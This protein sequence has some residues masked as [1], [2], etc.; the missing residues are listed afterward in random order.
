M[1]INGREK[2]AR[3]ERDMSKAFSDWTGCVWD[4]TFQSGG[5][6][7]KG[8]IAPVNGASSICVELKRREAWSLDQ[9]LT[10]KGDIW[11]WWGKL[12]K[13]AR[14]GRQHPVLVVKKNKLDALVVMQGALYSKLFNTDPS[15]ALRAGG[16][17]VVRLVDFLATDGSKVVLTLDSIGAGD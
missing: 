7:Q 17:V 6:K 11:E 13:E 10:S 14:E 15:F 12:K 1:T 2:G 16:V 8:D 9:L 3:F 5:G 4:R